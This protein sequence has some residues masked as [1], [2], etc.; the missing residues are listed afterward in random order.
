MSLSHYQRLCTQWLSFTLFF[1]VSFGAGAAEENKDDIRLEI[2]GTARTEI[3]RSSCGKKEKTAKLILPTRITQNHTDLRIVRM[4][5]TDKTKPQETKCP[6]NFPDG[7]SE[8]NNNMV[9]IEDIENPV[10]E[11]GFL[12]SKG[13]CSNSA[14]PGSN[15]LCIYPDTAGKTE[16]LGQFRYTYETTVARISE[17]KDKAAANGIIEFTVETKG[18]VEQVETCLSENTPGKNIEKIFTDASKADKFE[19]NTPYTRYKS[20][21]P[22]V[23]I[24]NLKNRVEYV[25]MVRPLEQGGSPGAWG[26]P[27]K[28]TPIPVEFPL[29]SYD[30]D[31]GDISWSCQTSSF[32]S[33]SFLVMIGALL[34]G[35]RFRRLAKISWTPMLVALIVLAPAQKSHADLGQVNIGLLGSMYRPDLD[36]EKEGTIFPF[37]KSHFRKNTSDENGPII[38]FLGFE[39][40]V[41]LFDDFGSLQLGVGL[42]YGYATGQGLEIDANGR[43]DPDKPVSAVKTTLHIYQVRPQLTYLFD[44]VKDSFPF[45]P[46]VRGALIANGY[47][48]TNSMEPNKSFSHDPHGL[49]FGYQGALGLMFMLDFLEPG[50]VRSAR[51]SGTLNHVYLKGELSYTKIDTFGSKGFQFSPKDVMGSSLPLMWTFGLVFELP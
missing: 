3:G 43:P 33:W 46:Y 26:E 2:K 32:S 23:R 42:G 40:D 7:Y 51:G 30:G 45:V 1:M 4:A 14:K 47:S 49:R 9:F 28:L 16:K 25:L 50:S 15:L 36:S 5:P 44:Y 41:H 13:Q 8:Q 35:L 27:F 38:P 29:G 19:C 22:H 34:L 39:V 18:K 6:D 37:Y 24:N 17:I 48:F 10:F 12:L 21:P 31:G 11:E 20:T